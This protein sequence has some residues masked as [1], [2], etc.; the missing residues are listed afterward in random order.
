MAAI[1]RRPAWRDSD[2]RWRRRMLV[3]AWILVLLPLMGALQALSLASRIPVPTVFLFRG[4]RTLNDTFLA[5]IGVYEPIVFCIGVVLL[6]SKERERRSCPLDWTRRLGVICSYVAFLLSAVQA[7]FIPALVLLGIAALFLSM[8]PKYQPATT[9][10]FID[11]SAAYLRYGPYPKPISLVVLAAFSSIAVLLACVPLFDALRSSGP[12]WLAAILLAPL[13]LFSVMHLG[14]VGL[15]CL[16]W[17]GVTLEDV[18]A[19]AVYFRLGL[20]L[21]PRYSL[22]MYPN[23]SGWSTTAFAVEAAK[24][25]I[26]VAI[27]IW[28]SVA[29][30][31]A[32]WQSKKANAA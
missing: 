4:V 3:G 27:A 23:G 17:S 24:W 22:W 2:P 12:K 21:R 15:Y 20:L 26:V 16:G 19:L 10:L 7:L 8:P 6:F 14:E 9:Q 18:Y 1:P 5:G 32:R 28:L 13:A 11:V 29:Q 30:L 31:A 25:C